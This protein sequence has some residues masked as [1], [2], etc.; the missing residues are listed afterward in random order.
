M[1]SF[2]LRCLAG[3]DNPDVLVA[4]HVGDD[5]NPTG[6]RHSNGDETLFRCRMIRVWKRYRQGITKYG[7]RLLEKSGASAD[8]V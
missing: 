6:A 3:A 4:V 7:R 5:Q 1:F 8:F 2:A